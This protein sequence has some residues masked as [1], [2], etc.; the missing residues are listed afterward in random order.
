MDVCDVR[1]AVRRAQGDAGVADPQVVLTSLRQEVRSAVEQL[2]QALRRELLELRAEPEGGVEYVVN[3][4]TGIA[5]RVKAAGPDV[6]RQEWTTAC[7][8]WMFGRDGNV[9]TRTRSRPADDALC[10]HCFPR[11][12]RAAAE[13]QSDSSS[14]SS[15]SDE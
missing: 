5:H 13:S 7:G 2:S 6:A 15:S 1:E 3:N 11:S 12:E 10:G 4:K 8:K 14:S 9:A